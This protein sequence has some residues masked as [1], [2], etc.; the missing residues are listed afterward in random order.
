M[1]MPAH[2][3]LVQAKRKYQSAMQEKAG[4]EQEARELQEKYRQKSK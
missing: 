4:L 2:C 3:H 1:A